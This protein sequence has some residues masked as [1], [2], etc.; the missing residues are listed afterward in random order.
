[1][2]PSLLMH[3]CFRLASTHIGGFGAWDSRNCRV[4]SENKENVTCGCDHL[5]HF[6]I[7]LVSNSSQNAHAIYNTEALY[8]VSHSTLNPFPLQDLSPTRPP[9]TVPPPVTLALTGVS[10]IGT[11]LSVICLTITII[12]Y[13]GEK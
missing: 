5:T 1:M 3:I 12:T 13:L 11:I 2:I 8:I 6:A 9:G 10:Y 7:L 4:L